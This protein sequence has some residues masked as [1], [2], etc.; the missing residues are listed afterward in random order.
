MGLVTRVFPADQLLDGTREYIR[1]NLARSS[2]AAMAEMKR[3]VWDAQFTDLAAAVKA[4]DDAMQRSFQRPDFKEGLTAF[5]E[6][7]AP[8]YAGIGE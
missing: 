4:A 2:P 1:Q 8:R 3:L 5:A 7:R 6:K